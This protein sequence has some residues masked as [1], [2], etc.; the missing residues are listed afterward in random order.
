M[1]TWQ[2]SSDSRPAL[3]GPSADFFLLLGILPAVQEPMYPIEFNWQ[4]LDR[5]LIRQFTMAQRIWHDLKAQRSEPLP[6]YVRELQWQRLQS[7]SRPL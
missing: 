4:E 3:S 1:N 6:R 7:S 5:E 2:L